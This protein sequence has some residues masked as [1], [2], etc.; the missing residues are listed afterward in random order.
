MA[1]IVKYWTIRRQYGMHEVL[2]VLTD[3]PGV[4]YISGS[5]CG[6]P[7]REWRDK[8]YGKF[9]TEQEA[10]I[11]ASEIYRIRDRF[12]SLIKDREIQIRKYR[13]EMET[14]ID[15]KVRELSNVEVVDRERELV[16]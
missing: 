15:A 11:A 16:Q 9:R 8:C 6:R 7:W 13:D 5:K 4:P 14:E 12:T 3:N 2:G 1:K 10:G